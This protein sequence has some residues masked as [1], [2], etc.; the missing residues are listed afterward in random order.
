MVD[1]QFHEIPTRSSRLALVPEVCENVMLEPVAV[2]PVGVA[3]SLVTGAA[4]ALAAGSTS[5][6]PITRATTMVAHI[7]ALRP[8]L[9]QPARVW[10][11]CRALP[12]VLMS[13]PCLIARH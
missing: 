10:L 11:V 13:A 1:P 4:S 3:P 9:E 2:V 12:S 6:R 8:R 5:I 7:S